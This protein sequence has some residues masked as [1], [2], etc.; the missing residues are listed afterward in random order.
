MVPIHKYKA[1]KG[2]SVSKRYAKAE[3]QA[4]PPSKEDHDLRLVRPGGHGA[5]GNARKECHC[6]QELYM[7]K[8]HHVKEGIWLKRPHRQGQTILLHDN[9]RPLVAQVV[10]AAL[11]DLGWEVLQHWLY[12]PDLTRT[13]Y[14]PFH[15]LSN[16]MKG[17]TFDSEEVLKN[18]PTQ[19]LR[20]QTERFLAERHRQV[21]REEGGG[22]K[23]QRRIH[24]WLIY[25]Y[26]YWFFFK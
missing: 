25:C 13:D 19:L 22:R 8:L 14:H 5:L 24:N 12:S 7:A 11:H 20:Y 10:K 1:K 2:V 15:S 17:L 6:Q 16:H 3:S 23:Q 9:A 26:N 4:W 18:W 21:G